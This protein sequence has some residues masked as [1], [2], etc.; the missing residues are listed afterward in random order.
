MSRYG[1]VDHANKPTTL[2]KK[3]D[4]Q[5]MAAMAEPM[6]EATVLYGASDTD[7]LGGKSGRGGGWGDDFGKCNQFINGV[8]DGQRHLEVFTNEITTI[9]L[10]D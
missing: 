10:A 6:I 8:D 2:G 5:A 9:Y 1:E 4:T 3:T 7:S